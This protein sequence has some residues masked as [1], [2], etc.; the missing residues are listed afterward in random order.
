MT[1]VN[2]QR[3]IFTSDDPR[4]R[5]P[6]ERD[7]RALARKLPARSE[8]ILLGSIATGKYVERFAGELWRPAPISR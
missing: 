4:Y 5:A 6:I 2:S 7:A 3:S 8:I 1:C